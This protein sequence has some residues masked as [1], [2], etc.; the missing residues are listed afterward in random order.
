MRKITKWIK[1]SLAN[2]DFSWYGF[3]FILYFFMLFLVISIYSSSSAYLSD[4]VE[5]DGIIIHVGDF[6][7]GR[8]YIAKVKRD[9]T[10]VRF[11]TYYEL[12]IGDK[13]SL[14]VMP[15]EPSLGTLGR[16]SSSLFDLIVHRNGSMG[17]AVFYLIL[18][19]FGIASG[20]ITAIVLY[21]NRKSHGKD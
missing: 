11:H 6:N 1:K 5:K 16:K 15:N 8:T 13:A 21:R 9:N 20:P 2:P 14:L 18:M 4:G 7:K 3:C 19:S 17:R 10:E 12:S